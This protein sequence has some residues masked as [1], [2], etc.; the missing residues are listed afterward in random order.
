MAAH[1]V[2]EEGE[3]GYTTGPADGGTN[4]IRA[5]YRGGTN[6]IEWV[7]DP[8]YNLFWTNNGGLSLF[9]TSTTGSFS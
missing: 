9:T 2:L 1:D 6:L 5:A 8:P 3:I 4:T 7:Y